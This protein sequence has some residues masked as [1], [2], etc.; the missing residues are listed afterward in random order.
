MLLQAFTRNNCDRKDD[1]DGFLERLVQ[2]APFFGVPTAEGAGTSQ[3][4]MGEQG[5]DSGASLDPQQ[6]QSGG[7]KGSKIRAAQ[8][9]STISGA[10][11]VTDGMGREIANMFPSDGIFFP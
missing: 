2:N 1:Q 10:A 4:A 5:G 3:A 9:L 6:Q 8:A 11:F 7:K